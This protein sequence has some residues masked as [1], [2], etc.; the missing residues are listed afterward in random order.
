L[1][2]EVLEQTREQVEL[3]PVIGK[4]LALWVAARAASRRS[5]KSITRLAAQIR[6][7]QL[8]GCGPSAFSRRFA[9]IAAAG[10]PRD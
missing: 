5:S 7:R 8:R 1:L 3:V 10:D 6:A 9:R 4:G 2:Q